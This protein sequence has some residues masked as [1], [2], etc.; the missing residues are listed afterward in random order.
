[1]F[2]SILG[3]KCNTE[4]QNSLFPTKPELYGTFG[5]KVGPKMHFS[6][7]I[8]YYGTFGG[9]LAKWGQKLHFFPLN[10]YYGTFPQ[11]ACIYGTF[12][13]PL[14]KGSKNCTVNPWW[15]HS[16]GTMVH[17]VGHWQNRETLQFCPVSLYCGT[18][19]GPLTN[20]VQKLH[21]LPV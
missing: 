16:T 5:G 9:P 6:T 19:G 14:A 18:Y 4:L 17:L 20:W 21:F 15:A 13:G 2:T 8:L 3:F 12:G 10:L 7:I 11:S 1:M